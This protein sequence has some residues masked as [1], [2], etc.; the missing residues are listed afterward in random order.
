[1]RT[2]TAIIIP[3]YNEENRLKVNAFI[4]FINQ[5]ED[6]HLCFVNDGSSDQTI[7]RLNEVK[8]AAPKKVTVIDLEVNV[9]KAEA[10][11]AGALQ[12]AQVESI[13]LIGFI[14][15]DLSTDF[16]DFC[17]LANTLKTNTDLD[18]VYGSRNS[19]EDQNIERNIF[20][21]IFSKIVKA[22]IY[23]ILGLPIDDTQCGAKVFRK[24]II[25]TSFGSKFL[26]RWL[27]DVEIFI[28]LKNHYGRGQ[29]MNHIMEQPLEKW[30]H[31]DDS[32]LGV[33]DAIQIPIKL[34]TIWYAYNFV[35][36]SSL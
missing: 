13:D 16:K 34:M 30:V 4:N 21:N 2:S 7:S 28:K 5:T 19:S 24:E 3:C 15:A 33:K 11:R 20:R 25:E 1:M 26:T 17:A 18:L 32:K 36:Q 27:F 29:I 9:G 35:G 22:I 23:L 8:A 6:Y 14:D 10:V 31:V 12:L